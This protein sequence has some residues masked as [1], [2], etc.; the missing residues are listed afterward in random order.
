MVSDVYV[1]VQ[2]CVI[3]VVVAGITEVVNGVVVGITEVID[4]V[5]F[6]TG[7]RFVKGMHSSIQ[8][9]FTPAT[10]VAAI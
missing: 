2:H 9:K 10:W 5:M 3:A 1:P 6:N 8:V 7:F 4:V